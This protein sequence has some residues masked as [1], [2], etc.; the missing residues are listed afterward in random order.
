MNGSNH[1][2]DKATLRVVSAPKLIQFYAKGDVVRG[3]FR[4][5]LLVSFFDTKT[6]TGAFVA[7]QSAQL[8]RDLEDCWKAVQ[9]HFGAGLSSESLQVKAIG[10]AECEKTVREFFKTHGADVKAFAPSPAGEVL[11]CFFFPDVGRLRVA[12]IQSKDDSQRAESRTTTV[13]RK[14]RVLIV[15]D[16]KTIRQL[17][18]KIIDSSPLLEVVGEAERPSQVEKMVD[19]LKPDV[20]TLD[21]N[22][23]EMSGVLLLEKLLAK[24][25]IPAVMISSLSM[26]EGNQV[27][28]ALELGAVDYIQK[29]SAAE[30]SHI[31]PLIQEKIVEAS[32]VRQN[33]RR[34][35]RKKAVTTGQKVSGR[36]QSTRLLAVGASTG[37]TEAIKNIFLQ[38]PKETPPIVVVQHIP[39]YFS[40]AFANRLNS[41]CE[42][43]VREAVDGDELVPGLALVAPGGLHLEVV[44]KKGKLSVKVYD[45]AAVNRFKPSVD[46]MFKSVAKA[47]GK[48]AVGVLLTGMGTDGAKGLLD[49]KNVGSFTLAQDQESCVVFGMPRAA[50]EIGAAT[51]VKPLDDIADVLMKAS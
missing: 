4:G 1:G 32:K 7:C 29:P 24:R 47:V 33:T 25:F 20:M 46:V 42:F 30:M 31:I 23:P 9:A 51:E 37:G 43:E 45:G 3:E 38:F 26:E 6:S 48:E 34:Q 49:M 19:D 35:I 11:E 50:I 41:I 2:G 16:S 15:D 27:L 21:I 17:L 5:D 28:N 10:I 14:I 40:K 18:H 39:P 36:F 44:N 8:Q 13:A 22:M 12:P